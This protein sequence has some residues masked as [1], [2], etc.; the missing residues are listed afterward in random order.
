MVRF[1]GHFTTSYIALSVIK[2]LHI[3]MEEESRATLLEEWSQGKQE[4]GNLFLV[5]VDFKN[6]WF[7]NNDRKARQWQFRGGW[8]GSCHTSQI[9]L[10]YSQPL[11][12]AHALAVST[13]I[14]KPVNGSA[15]Y[16]VNSLKRPVRDQGQRRERL[17]GPVGFYKILLPT[18]PGSRAA[19]GE[20][21]WR[22]LCGGQSFACDLPQY[23]TCWWWAVCCA[24]WKAVLNVS[25]GKWP[26]SLRLGKNLS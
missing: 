19:G 24:A 20:P 7:N 25:H 18:D 9:G 17:D 5:F 1:P 4:Y 22:K 21:E 16:K 26:I 2:I 12:D 23:E 14:W 3:C 15:T 8:G 10:I 13:L 6:S 11:L